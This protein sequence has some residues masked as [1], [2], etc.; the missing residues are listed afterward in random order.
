LPTPHVYGS[1][2]FA[3]SSESRA[4][5]SLKTEHNISKHCDIM[6]ESNFST[7]SNNDDEGAFVHLVNENT[8]LHGHTMMAIEY[9]ASV[10]GGKHTYWGLSFQPKNEGEPISGLL[11]KGVPAKLVIDRTHPGSEHPGINGKHSATV[12]SY[13]IT[14]QQK[15]AL[16]Q[17]I[18][19]EKTAIALG[20]VIY[21]NFGTPYAGLFFSGHR[22]NC[23]SWACRVLGE[24]GIVS[25]AWALA[26]PLLILPT[27]GEIFG[28]QKR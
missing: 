17:V 19:N 23:Y 20:S 4:R 6:W 7:D 25:P 22:D 8:T 11:V 3:R 24:A 9:P 15:V 12:N 5:Q 13:V 26:R 16:H 10:P 21:C 28:K 2:A 14:N 27:Q 18:E 1:T